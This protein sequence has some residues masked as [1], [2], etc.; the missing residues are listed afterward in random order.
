MRTVNSA[1]ALEEQRLPPGGRVAVPGR[2]SPWVWDS[3]PGAGPPVV[4]LH[5][6]TSTAA[7]TWQMAAGPLAEH[8][9][10][11]A[12]DLR[13]HG[14]GIRSRPPFRLEACADDVAGLIEVLGCGPCVVV[15]YSMGGPVAQLLWRR[16]PA[17][18]RSLVLCAT[19]CTFAPRNLQATALA[20]TALGLSVATATV[21]GILRSAGM[22]QMAGSF[23]RNG[24]RRTGWAAE[25]WAGADPA[26]LFGAGAALL[27]FDSSGWIG[28]VDVPTTVVVTEQDE[29]VP[30]AQQRRLA[31][32]VAGARVLT[33]AGG[34]RSCVEQADRFVPALL[35]ACDPAP[36]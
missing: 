11:I 33:V 36:S 6:W 4:L 9:R 3:G 7:L 12:P 35:E 10:V 30:P 2:G 18:V 16:H 32:S 20:A 13:C 22:R 1:W 5:G 24:P 8:H 21:P 15:G 34:H 26:G 14:R 28:D 23:P 27:R 17:H 29:T 31:A 19:A 25:E